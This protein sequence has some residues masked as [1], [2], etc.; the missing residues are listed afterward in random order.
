MDKV[1]TWDVLL[2]FQK[3]SKINKYRGTIMR[4]IKDGECSQ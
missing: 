2:K 4:K 1:F 3:F